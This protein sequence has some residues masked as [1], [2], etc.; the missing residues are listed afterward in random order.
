MD[1]SPTRRL[2]PGL[3]GRE[4]SSIRAMNRSVFKRCSSFTKACCASLS[5]MSATSQDE[6]GLPHWEAT[7]LTQ[8]AGTHVTHKASQSLGGRKA[9]GPAMGA[10]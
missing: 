1:A 3:R 2:T 5:C 6:Q 8:G 10:L 7:V 4:P 9:T